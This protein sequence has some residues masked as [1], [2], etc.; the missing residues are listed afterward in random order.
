MAVFKILGRITS[1]LAAGTVNDN[2]FKQLLSKLM[3]IK[4]EFTSKSFDIVSNLEE[5]LIIN[6]N[7][8]YNKD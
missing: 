4:R 1:I 8:I 6:N 2:N 3:C 5:T 7:K